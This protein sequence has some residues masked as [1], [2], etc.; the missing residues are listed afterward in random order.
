MIPVETIGVFFAISTMMAMAPGPDNIFVLTQSAIHGRRTGLLVLLGLCT[1]L[2][3]HTAM[4][5]FGVAAIFQQSEL[6]FNLLKAVGA[7]YLCWLAWQ[8]FT[9]QPA[10]I[11][12]APAAE[13]SAKALYLRGI[14]MNLTN[15]K[16]A[17]FFLAFLPQ[18]AKP[19]NGSLAL[20]IMMLGVLVIISTLMVFSAIAW[21]AGKIGNY[22]KRSVA[23]QKVLNR[24]AGTVFGA[25][26]IKLA[27][28][29][30]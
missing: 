10:D 4:V 11:N 21:G 28:A 13:R 22:L 7:I 6:A 14:V 9:A 5:A 30:R 12:A 26:A 27:L 25:L 18:F 17:I 3:F 19:E 20:Q 29:D 16:V 15:P 24:V 2:M 1:G 8:A 23:A